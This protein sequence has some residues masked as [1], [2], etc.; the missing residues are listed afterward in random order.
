MREPTSFGQTIPKEAADRFDEFCESTGLKKWRALVAALELI[1]LA[2]P[3]LR[4]QLMAGD[5]QQAAEWLEAI[6]AAT[7]LEQA[8]QRAAK[9]PASKP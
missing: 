5:P 4:D 8:A 2:P 6:A 7:E 9:E 3:G 1:R